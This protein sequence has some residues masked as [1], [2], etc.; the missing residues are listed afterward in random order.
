MSGRAHAKDNKISKETTEWYYE[1]GLRDYL[2]SSVKGCI[3][4]PEDEPFVGAFS[5]SY[6][7]ADWLYYG[8]L[9]VVIWLLKVMLT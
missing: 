2:L 1:D 7:V 4:L 6:G 9:K 3:T 8:Y 5:A